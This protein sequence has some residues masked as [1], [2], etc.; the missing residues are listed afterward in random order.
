MSAAATSATSAVVADDASASPL[1]RVVIV[2]GGFGGVRA[3]QALAHAEV[4]VTLIDRTNHHLFQPLLYQVATGVLSPGQIA[5]ALRSLFRHQQ[6]VDVVLGEVQDVDV[7]RRSVR[8]RG[9]EETDIAY[10]TLVVAAG[11]THSYF[12]HEEW[13]AIAPGMK[14]L[15][16][17][18]R[19]RSRILAAFEMADQEP[20]PEKRRAWLTFAIVGAG[21]TGVELAGQVSLLAHRVLRGEYRHIDPAGARVV[22]LDASA[23]VLGGFANSLRARA[24]RDLQRLGVDVELHSAVTEMDFQGVLVGE[25]ESRRRIEA[26]T[27]IWA[28]GVQASPLGRILADRTGAVLDRAGRLH[29][30]PDLTLPGHSEVFAIGD[31]ITLAG[32]P[33]TAQ[34][35][36]QEG[37]YVAGV[38]RARLDG[39]AGAPK[40]FRY[41]DL[42][43]MAVIGRSQAVA[44]IFGRVRLG[45][46]PAFLI[47]GAIHLAYLVGWGNRFGAVSRWMWTILARNRRER[48]I[49]MAS[50]PQ[51]TGG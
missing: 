31:M 14:T 29:V 23:S 49:S 40:P 1:H 21:P 41:R 11:A 4:Q 8:V 25:G 20:D 22:L 38:V 46:F 39:A 33:G 43:M 2:G 27:V 12:A 26:R 13:A 17:A 19:L 32:V 48:L 45:G 5:P 15:Q 30:E 9:V 47:W 6:R 44:D 16:D 50:L 35:A 42:G 28:A 3:A 36:I 51:D 18:D 34:P 7:E 10:D 37:K 24:Q